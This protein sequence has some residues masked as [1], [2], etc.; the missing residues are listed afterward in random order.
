MSKN[1]KIYIIS[2]LI[3][4]NIVPILGMFFAMIIDFLLWQ[5]NA[6]VFVLSVWYNAYSNFEAFRVI[7]IS[8]LIFGNIIFCVLKEQFGD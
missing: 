2:S 3:G 7:L 4:A 8:W 5:T 6:I 1:L